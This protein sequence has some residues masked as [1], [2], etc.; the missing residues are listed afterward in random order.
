ML[1]PP[2]NKR[3]Q[4]LGYPKVGFMGTGHTVYSALH[5]TLR[6]P[7]EQWKSQLDREGQEE[8]SSLVPK[9]IWSCL[10]ALW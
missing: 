7:G 3:W 6:W 10:E 8:N 2:D 5:N 4:S 9:G 1:L